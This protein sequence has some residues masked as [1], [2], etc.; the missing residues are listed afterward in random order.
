MSTIPSTTRA[1]ISGS[2][3]STLIQ[4]A[5]ERAEEIGVPMS[6]AVVDESG[7]LKAYVRMDGA[8]LLAGQVAIDKAYTAAGFG[9]ATS[10]WHDFIKDDPPLAAGAP[11]GVSRLIVFGGGYPL[12]DG[13]Q[14]IGGLG[15]SG[16]HYDQDMDVA[17]AALAAFE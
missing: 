9:L 8:A 14:V 2:T 6:I 15:V 1:T 16:G 5:Q 7:I 10:D 17:L 13:D 11:T 4:H 3:A 12:R